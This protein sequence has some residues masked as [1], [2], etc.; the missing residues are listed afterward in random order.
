MLTRNAATCLGWAVAAFFLLGLTGCS[1]DFSKVGALPDCEAMYCSGQAFTTKKM[2]SGPALMCF[3]CSWDPASAALMD[4]LHKYLREHPDFAKNNQLYFVS[5]N[6]DL[7]QQQAIAKRFSKFTRNLLIDQGTMAESFGV[8]LVPAI[9]RI[10]KAH[11]RPICTGY[12][13]YA[14][15][16]GFL[17]QRF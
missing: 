15:L 14:M 17:D 8:H 2:S 4:E 3:Y 5:V 11:Y 6:G 16:R 10:D 1:S 9:L 13:E 7:E 12:V